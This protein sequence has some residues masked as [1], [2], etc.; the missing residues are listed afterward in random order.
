MDDTCWKVKCKADAL[1]WLARGETSICRNLDSLICD[2]YAS[3]S[4][5][6]VH[7]FPLCALRARSSTEVFL[8]MEKSNDA[9]MFRSKLVMHVIFV[10]ALESQ[11]HNQKI[12][13]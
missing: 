11:V 12:V 13:S 6:R 7:V 5:L 1:A 3:M 10:D 9:M 4:H 8:A 2:T